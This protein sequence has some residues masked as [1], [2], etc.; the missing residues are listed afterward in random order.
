MRVAASLAV[1]SAYVAPSPRRGAI[2]LAR[3]ARRL[4]VSPVCEAEA[5]LAGG[6]AGAGDGLSATVVTDTLLDLGVYTILFSVVA[7]TLYSLFVT[8]QKSNEEYG[9]WTP[10]DDEDITS[11][12]ATPPSERLRPGAKY[13]PVT[14]TWTYPQPEERTGAKVGRAPAAAMEDSNSNRYER[15]AAKKQRKAARKGK[16]GR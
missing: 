9:G 5:E 12:A 2:P 16:K 8:L 4:G 15:R 13:D 3:A 10:R 11:L 1:A 7:L 6:A 14:D